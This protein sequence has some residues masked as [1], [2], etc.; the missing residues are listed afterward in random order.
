MFRR[1][2][3]SAGRGVIV[4]LAIWIGISFAEVNAGN[5]G[6]NHREIGKYNVFGMIADYAGEMSD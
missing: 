3:K 4:A 6:G 5:I 2:A 1:L